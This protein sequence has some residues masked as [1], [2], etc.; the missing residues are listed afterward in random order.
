M[1]LS[2]TERDRDFSLDELR[3]KEKEERDFSEQGE[4]GMRDHR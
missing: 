3:E 4:S 2:L 1:D